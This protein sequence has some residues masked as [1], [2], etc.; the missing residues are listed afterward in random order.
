MA[1]NRSSRSRSDGSDRRNRRRKEDRKAR[2]QDGK[3]RRREGRR[4][5]KKDK[6]RDRRDRDRDASSN[7]DPDAPTKLARTDPY[8]LVAGAEV[9][10]AEA[11]PSKEEDK[12]VVISDDDNNN[13]NIN[14]DDGGEQLQLEETDEAVEK[15]ALEAKKRR[16]AL[17]KKRAAEAAELDEPTLQETPSTAAENNDSTKVSDQTSKAGGSLE[18][19]LAVNRFILQSREEEDGGDMFGD[20]E[21]TDPALLNTRIEKKKAGGMHINGASGDDWDDAEGYYKPTVGEILADRYEVREPNCGK[22]VF[23]GVVKAV[24]L[25]EKKRGGDNCMVAI[26]ITRCNDMMRKAAEKEA[27]VL[28]R[29]Q[30][31][32]KLGRVNII[33]MLRTFDY[34]KHYCIVFECMWDNLR[35]ALKKHTSNKGMSLRT[36]RSYSKQLLFS[37]Q[38]IHQCEYV[39]ADIKPDNVLM[40]E[41]QNC[42]KICDLGSA[43]A[44][45]EVETTA[46]LVSRWYRAPEICLGIKY[47]PASDTWALGCSLMELFTGK[48]IFPGRSNN[49]M[50][51]LFMEVKGKLPHNLIKRGTVWK[52]HFN[53]QMDFTFVEAIDKAK[54]KKI[55]VVTDFSTKR[56]IQD[57]VVERLGGPERQRSNTPMDNFRFKKGK[58]FASLIEQMTTLDPEKRPSPKDLLEHPFLQEAWDEPSS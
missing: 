17:M 33:R 54:R 44:F 38:H 7:S 26:K 2:D 29:L 25:K 36:V 28:T 13:E 21:D 50:L 53:A 58:Q 23:S 49:D 45:S 10:D 31:A 14:S 34:R 9:I 5:E 56:S 27:E 46:Y 39:H 48:P 1:R 52:Q 30:K 47:G 22:G 4:K 32:D 35:T 51:R 40:T 19:K 24:D 6:K 43:V 15:I 41:G 55:R 20:M 3:S 42:V 18:E 12:Q 16:E 57:M 37:L 11:L 8:Q